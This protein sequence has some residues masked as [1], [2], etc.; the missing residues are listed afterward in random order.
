MHAERANVIKE[1]Y[2]RIVKTQRA[3][4]SL[5]RPLQLVG[6]PTQEEKTKQLADQFNDLSNYYAE[7]RL[8]FGEELAQ[9]IDGLLKKFMDIWHQWN[10]AKDLRE[11]RTPDVKE[12]GRAWDQVKGEVPLIKESIE[13]GFRDIIGIE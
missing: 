2:K 1:V 6:E 5:I 7:N 9:E 11:G 8:F 13:K 4:E 12:W 10:Y 3:F